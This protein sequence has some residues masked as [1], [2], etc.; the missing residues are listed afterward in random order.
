M[1]LGLL[2]GLVRRCI[3]KLDMIVGGTFGCDIPVPLVIVHT[4]VA[5]A[6]MR[7]DVIIVN[8]RMASSTC[9]VTVEERKLRSRC[10]NE[11]GGSHVRVP[12]A[13][14]GVV[15][16]FKD[17]FALAEIVNGDPD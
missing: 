2:A 12:I 4:E 14:V 6:C 15:R 7:D 1:I 9:P 17:G 5:T 8:I 11:F 10:A 16:L 13:L 3:I